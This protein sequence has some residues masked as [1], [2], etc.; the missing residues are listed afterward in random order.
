MRMHFKFVTYHFGE[1]E[2]VSHS[3]QR[4]YSELMDDLLRQ[5][6]QHSML[7][8]S[9]QWRPPADIHETPDAIQVKLELA[10]VREEDLN[11]TLYEDALVV[12]GRREDDRDETTEVCYHEARIRYGPFRAE[13]MLPGRVRR[14]GV[15]AT[16]ANGFL[17]VLLPKAA[18][19]AAES[20]VPR[21]SLVTR[22]RKA[23][24]PLQAAT[25]AVS[26]AASERLSA[27]ARS[28]TSEP[29][30]RR[31]ERDERDETRNAQPFRLL[32]S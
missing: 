3:L 32:L 29:N 14:E 30:R 26:S 13:I 11:I 28:P 19:S 2:S 7:Q 15:A 12:T 31:N 25:F 24:H 6:P 18:E 21:P 27:P 16:Y 1:D 9:A 10:G 8:R 4:H 17:R 22:S 5:S 20:I 23:T